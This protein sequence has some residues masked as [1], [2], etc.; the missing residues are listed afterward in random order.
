MARR[1]GFGPLLGI[2]LLLGFLAR[3]GYV[4]GQAA[5][6]PTAG[7]PM[8]DG[9]YFLDW[10]RALV[11]GRGGPLLGHPAEAPSAFYLAPLYPLALAG[12]FLAFGEN[13]SLLYYA[14]QLLVL[15]AAA[16][17]AWSARRLV[18][19][20]AAVAAAGILLAYHP[21][22]FFASRPVGEP[23][24][25]LLLAAALAA[26]PA[27]EGAWRS[28][29]G[30][31]LAGLAAV[32]RP[33]LI[34]APVVWAAIAATRGRWGRAGLCAAGA[35]LALAPTLVRNWSVSGHP[36]PVSAN[37][38]MTLY[39]GNG[40]GAAGIGWFV[41]GMTGRLEEQQ[42]EA[43][44]LASFHAERGLDPVEADGW[45]ARQAVRARLD[46]VGGTIGLVARR[47]ALLVSNEEL[48]LDYAP[49]L[50]VAG[51]RRLAP[52]PF[53]AVLGLAAGGVV[54]RG[55]ARTGG[56]LV[57][58][59]ALA[60]AVAP[61]AFFVSSRYR[62]PLAAVLS[63]PAGAGLV[64]ILSRT[65]AMRRRL[66][67]AGAA[68]AVGLLSV[69]IPTG[70]LARTTEAVARANRAL[71]LRRTGDPAR[72]EEE[73]K[74][75]LKLDPDSVP[76]LTG[77]QQLLSASGRSDEFRE[78]YERALEVHPAGIAQRWEN[79]ILTRVAAGNVAGAWQ[80]MESLSATGVAIDPEIA[81]KLRHAAG[82][83]PAPAAA[84]DGSR[85]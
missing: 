23:L 71:V 44:R 57:W 64:A 21:A 4:L 25:L 70:G 41:R 39:H 27:D 49:D 52:L 5:S 14:Q 37:G 9:A 3:L 15:G 72:A 66:S 13:L 68:A 60:C 7:V 78:H 51:W 32:A 79:E 38:G 63:I 75:A 1:I 81:R 6:D 31:W 67:A 16:G 53:A 58:G 43:T 46:D 45:W 35:M 2:V 62:L 30:G 80:T 69:L 83:P 65:T 24:A 50:D 76:A 34:L 55:W 74:L 17:L 20:G 59:T 11:D 54:A 8:L 28:A 40:P 77:L 85:P 22:L 10:A 29:L 61:L 56:A 73:L 18:G 82:V 19:D 42:R 47:A 26:G 33:N 48:A 84:G 12:F 36:V